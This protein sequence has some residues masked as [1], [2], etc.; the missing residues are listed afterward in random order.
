MPPPSG[1][2]PSQYNPID[3]VKY[4]WEKFTQNLGPLLGLTAIILVIG[5]CLNMVI[6]LAFTGSVL[7]SSASTVDPETGLPD[8]FLQAQLASITSSFVTG[9]ISWALG[10]ALVRGALDIVDRGRT[11]FGEMFSRI[12]WGQAIIAGLL[13]WL[14]TTVGIVLCVIPGIIV[15][16]LLYYTNI[17]VVDGR[18]ATDAMG[19]S[20]TFVRTTW[21]RTCCSSWSPSA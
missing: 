4:G 14:A 17:A 1:P 3:A 15:M 7:G 20:F 12:P 16:F 9:F 18:S 6:N 10:L 8:N 19:A 13:V 21:P 11:S 2:A 5:I